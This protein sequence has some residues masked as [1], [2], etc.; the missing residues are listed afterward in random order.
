MRPKYP[1]PEKDVEALGPAGLH[2]ELGERMKPMVLKTIVPKGT[3]RSNRTLSS[4]SR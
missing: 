4:I 3:V 1:H 2:G